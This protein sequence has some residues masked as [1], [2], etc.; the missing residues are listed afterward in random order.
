MGTTTIL[1]LRL[2]FEIVGTLTLFP[3]IELRPVEKKL[4]FQ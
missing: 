2:S 4:W 1:I 3:I